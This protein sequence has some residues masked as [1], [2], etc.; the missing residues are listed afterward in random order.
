[1]RASEL[2]RHQ[3]FFADIVRKAGNPSHSMA[4]RLAQEGARD[5]ASPWFKISA[6]LAKALT[7]GPLSG[8]PQK[9]FMNLM[10]QVSS[11]QMM[12]R[13]LARAQELVMQSVEVHVGKLRALKGAGAHS[14]RASTRRT[15]RSCAVMERAG[16]SWS[17]HQADT[18][19]PY[20]AGQVFD[21]PLDVLAKRSKNFLLLS[22]DSGVVGFIDLRW[23][24]RGRRHALEDLKRQRWRR[25]VGLLEEARLYRRW[26][27]ESRATRDELATLLVTLHPA[28][29]PLS[30]LRELEAQRQAAEFWAREFGRMAFENER[31]A[32][33]LHGALVA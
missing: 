3:A 32:R 16:T 22:D 7:H 27:S 18:T 30:E 26:S 21:I 25:R 6:A 1:M 23:D 24:E 14:T 28:T 20:S 9:E 15:A 11:C 8:G 10:N 5:R 33:R 12:T 4:F 17:L 31:E 13:L 19:L 29:T 2:L